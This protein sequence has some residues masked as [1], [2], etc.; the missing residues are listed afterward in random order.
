MKPVTTKIAFY[1]LLFLACYI[2]KAVISGG[3]ITN[4]LILTAIIGGFIITIDLLTNIGDA[5]TPEEVTKRHLKNISLIIIACIIAIGSASCIYLPNVEPAAIWITTAADATI[6]T[7]PITVNAILK[8]RES[9]HS[10]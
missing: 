2:V 6:A 4:A 8:Y 7:S 1:V 3:N 5:I 9:C 10:T